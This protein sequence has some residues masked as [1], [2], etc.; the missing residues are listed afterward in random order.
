MMIISALFSSL[1]PGGWGG[2]QR[3][4]LQGGIPAGQ[5]EDQQGGDWRWNAMTPNIYDH[6]SWHLPRAT[7][8]CLWTLTS[9]FKQSTRSNWK[10]PLWGWD[11]RQL[12]PKYP[13]IR[14]SSSHHYPGGESCG[15]QGS[16]EGL[17]HCGGLPGGQLHVEVQ[18]RDHSNT[19]WAMVLM[20]IVEPWQHWQ[21][22]LEWTDFTKYPESLQLG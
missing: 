3:H 19:G 12:Y 20:L 5:D 10:K 13:Q 17:V 4:A 2:E 15:E 21:P 22:Q 6:Q 9:Q 1:S 14:K 11:W 7:S 16:R 18:R 8:L